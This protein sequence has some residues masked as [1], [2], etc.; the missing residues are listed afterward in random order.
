MLSLIAQG[1]FE[2]SLVY[3]D[4]L[5]EVPDVERFSRMALAVDSFHKKDFTKAQYWLKLSLESDLDRLLSG[6]MS[7]WAMEG[8]VK[9]ATPWRSSTSCRDRTGS[10]CSNPTI[11]L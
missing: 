9:P 6:V 11:A 4:K 10:A 3:A 8:A 2:E 1:R 5:K 7:G